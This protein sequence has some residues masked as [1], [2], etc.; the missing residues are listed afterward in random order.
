[1]E[2]KTLELN[3][4]SAKDLNNVN[5][6]YKMDVYAVVSIFGDPLHK[7]KTKTPLDREAGT[8][9]TWNFSVKFTFNE[10]LARQNRLTLKITL[11]CLRNLVD[12][13]IG[14]VKIPLRELVHDH[15]GDGELFQHVSYQVRKPSGKPKGSFNFSYKFNPPMKEHATG[16]PSPA[17]GSTSAPHT[18]ANL[19]PQPQYPAGYVYPPPPPYHQPPQ[20][21]YG[22][23]QQME[24]GYPPQNAYGYPPQNNYGYPQQNGYGVP[25]STG[26]FV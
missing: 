15:T 18:V 7:Q 16:Y 19:S 8:N 9:P 6:F 5:L 23:P 11:R 24:Y 12:K 2:Y 3:L 17:V 21:G 4:S 10:L 13:N 22:Y 25:G 14:S 26:I 20:M 1:M